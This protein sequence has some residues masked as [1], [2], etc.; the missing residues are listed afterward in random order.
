MNRP[1]K[2]GS[3]AVAIKLAPLHKAVAKSLTDNGE[4]YFKGQELMDAFGLAASPL[5]TQ[6]AISCLLSMVK[7][8]RAM[9]CQLL[10]VGF[11]EIDRRQKSYCFT[12][13]VQSTQHDTDPLMVKEIFKLEV[14][15]LAI[16]TETARIW[17]H[18][19][20]ARPVSEIKKIANGL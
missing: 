12:Y 1:Q 6:E 13:C 10:R 3:G 14:P 4:H 8:L 16:A 18:A 2:P 20:K 19:Y 11:R 7:E 9:D 15:L 5:E 17:T